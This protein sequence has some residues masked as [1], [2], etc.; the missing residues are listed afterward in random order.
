M[1]ALVALG[2]SYPLWA[3]RRAESATRSLADEKERARVTLHSI[4][5]GVI[6]T[7]AQGLVEYMNPAAEAL[8]GLSADSA[9]GLPLAN[10]FRLTDAHDCPNDPVAQCL[11]QGQVI[12][13]A[14]HGRLL[15]RTG[16]EYVVRASAAP[17]RGQGGGMTGVVV[18]LNDVTE[19]ELMAQH[20]AHQANHDALTELPN[21]YLLHDRLSHAIARAQRNGMRIAVLFLDLDQFKTV[22]DSLGHAAGDELLKAVAARL[23]DCVRE[24][25][26]VARLGGDEFVIVLEHLR[27]EQTAVAVARKILGALEPPFLLQGHELF[28]SG[29]IGVSL[30]PKDGRDRETL[31]R[32]ADTAMYRAKEQGRNAFRFYAT[33][34]NLRALERLTL[35]NA[36]RHALERNELLLHYQ[37]SVDLQS[38]R[39]TGA[40]ALLRWQHPQRGLI[41]P[42]HFIPLAEE[43]GL[44][45]PIGEWVLGTACQQ[46]RAWQDQD[47]SLPRVAVNLSA[48]QFLHV[49]PVRHGRAHPGA[50]RLA[51]ASLELEITE[52]VL[53]NDLESARHHLA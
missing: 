17:I 28:V 24:E 39:I 19:T 5:D 21:R 15:S 12:S 52:G 38:G 3:L 11:Q 33:E 18:A 37:P 2:L 34:M 45:L 29:S 46:A 9:R 44:I 13:V 25:D 10:V 42:A 30:F 20:L 35:E 8:T 31:L 4:G 51:G 50:D 26:S 48:R 36:L 27:A 53:M 1:P 7:N 16:H 41:P 43:T 6:T 32:N 22:N 23:Q 40:E 14:E 47:I 49:R